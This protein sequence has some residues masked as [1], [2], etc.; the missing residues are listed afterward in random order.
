MNNAV[1]LD[2]DGTINEQ[3]EFLRAKKEFKFLP[4]SIQALKALSKS[5]YAIIVVSNQP[6]VGRGM[7]SPKEFESVQAFIEKQYRQHGIRIDA[8]FYCF[9]HPTQGIG[10]FN[11]EC[12]CRKPKPGLLLQAAK[13]LKIDLSSSWMVGDR[14]SDIAA[15]KAAGTRTILVKTGDGG[16][17]GVDP[18][19]KSDYI[20]C[21][22]AE[23]VKII[24]RK[25]QSVGQ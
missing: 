13:Q 1:F 7:L 12:A 16:E 25:T 14:R 9:H 4:N 20:A 8:S 18:P 21:D 6:V 15:G 23:A 5:R 3:V 10:I 2:R 24:L 19:I 17:G 11:K 22:L